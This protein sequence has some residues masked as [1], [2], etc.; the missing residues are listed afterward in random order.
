MTNLSREQDA[1][2]RRI[3]DLLGLSTLNLLRSTYSIETD[4]GQIGIYLLVQ[5]EWVKEVWTKKE[6]LL[7]LR[8]L[9]TKEG[10]LSGVDIHIRSDGRVSMLLR[11]ALPADEPSSMNG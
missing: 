7:D 10:G 11:F 6:Y 3:Q 8:V 2:F 1:S 9:L 5:P 4:G